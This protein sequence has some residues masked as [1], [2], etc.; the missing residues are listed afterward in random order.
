MNKR[1]IIISSIL[2]LLTLFW[3]FFIFSNSQDTAS[4]SS[5]KSKSVQEIVNE[6]IEALGGKGNVTEYAIRKFA[7]LFE[8][9]VLSVLFTADLLSLGAIP[10][11][12]KKNRSLIWLAAII[13]VSSLIATIDEAAIQNLSEGRGPSSADVGIDTLGAICGLCLSVLILFIVSTV[14]SKRKS[15]NS[16]V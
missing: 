15:G 8:Y 13:V 9:A 5:S 7:H 14:Y 2:I 3:I 10:F 6:I 4:E 12:L 11:P 16:S 1:K